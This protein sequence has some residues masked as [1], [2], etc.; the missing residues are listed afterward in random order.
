MTQPGP[1]HILTQE[2]I[3]QKWILI[4]RKFAA[5]KMDEMFSTD[6]AWHCQFR[7]VEEVSDSK[8]PECCRSFVTLL[9]TIKERYEPI[10]AA[11]DRIKFLDLQL[12]LLDDYRMS[13]S[14]ILLTLINIKMTYY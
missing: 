8:V 1:L 11:S 12:E 9:Q 5:E 7:E 13:C 6:S 10:H 4:E 2:R 3:F 14:M